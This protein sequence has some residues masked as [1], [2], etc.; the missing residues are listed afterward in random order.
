MSFDEMQV[1]N[2]EINSYLEYDIGKVTV[3]DNRYSLIW[4]DSVRV[5]LS[6]TI[7]L[8]E[9]EDV[10]EYTTDTEYESEFENEDY[11][12]DDEYE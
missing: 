12:D 11:S 10:P 8:F 4:D 6:D 5:E 7:S 3:D 2:E 9:T 1:L